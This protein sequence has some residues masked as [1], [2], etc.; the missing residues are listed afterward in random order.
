MRARST[1]ISLVCAL[2]LLVAGCSS[3]VGGT[4]QMP[5]AGGL[6]IS[7]PG[8][9]S[10]AGPTGG[11]ISTPSG[12]G[13]ADSGSQTDSDSSTN[14]AGSTDSGGDSGN[15]GDSSLPPAT[16]DDQTGMPT[17]FPTDLS[18]IPGLSDQCLAVSGL[19]ITVGMLLIAPMMGQPLT[20]QQVD[21][22]F[23]QMGDVPAELQQPMAVLHDAA[24]QSIG[25]STT[26]AAAILGSDQVSK[27]MDALSQYM[28]AQCGGG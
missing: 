25:K 10:G 4:P 3:S 5:A 16:D 14:D 15:G 8:G 20:K 27:A 17:A 1:V 6:N 11:P 24:E 18:G 2:G 7:T 26:E 9:Q 23:A 21:Q 22:A 13:S 28:D 12:D 19:A